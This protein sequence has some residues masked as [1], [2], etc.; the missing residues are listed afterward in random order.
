MLATRI[1]STLNPRHSL[2]ITSAGTQTTPAGTQTTPAGTRQ[3]RHFELWFPASR[4]A[5]GLQLP[6]DIVAMAE[7]PDTQYVIGKAEGLYYSF[8]ALDRLGDRSP[9]REMLA[10]AREAF[11]R[12]QHRRYREILSVSKTY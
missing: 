9:A 5:I 12:T 6:R 3:T 4:D 2:K 1:E 7:D 11:K 8:L 10:L